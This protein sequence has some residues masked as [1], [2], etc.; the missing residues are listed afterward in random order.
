MASLVEPSLVS[1]RSAASDRKGQSG[2]AAGFPLKSDRMTRS[3][4]LGDAA[5]GQSSGHSSFQP[6]MASSF[7]S[8]NATM[9]SLARRFPF[10]VSESGYGTKNLAGD[11]GRARSEARHG[12]LDVRSAGY[13]SLGG[14]PY[15]QTM[16]CLRCSARFPIAN[17]EEY[18]KHIRDCYSDTI[19]FS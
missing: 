9:P 8:P 11:S 4:L 16:Q 6:P 17:L 2:T 19:N 1:R 7:S 18:E 10:R 12:G 14:R 15:R 13:V 3:L 5:N